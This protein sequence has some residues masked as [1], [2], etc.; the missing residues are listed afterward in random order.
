MAVDICIMI[1]DPYYF[2][3]NNKRLFDVPEC[4]FFDM[5]FS[6]HSI[7]KN[8]VPSTNIQSPSEFEA[9]ILLRVNQNRLRTLPVAKYRL[10][11][12]I[13]EQ[14]VRNRRLHYEAE[15]RFNRGVESV[16]PSEILNLKHV[17]H[18]MLNRSVRLSLK[19]HIT[20]PGIVKSA[21]KFI[22]DHM[23]T[24]IN[25]VMLNLKNIVN[26]KA[27]IEY[28]IRHDFPDIICI[29]DIKY[30]FNVIKYKTAGEILRHINE[31]FLK[32]SERVFSKVFSLAQVEYNFNIEIIDQ[33][34]IKNAINEK[35]SEGCIGCNY[36]R[37]DDICIH[38]ALMKVKDRNKILYFPYAIPTWCPNQNF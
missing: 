37:R 7:Y 18:E 9:A 4:V 13:D 31:L 21:R 36:K 8:A 10:W 29:L 34:E 22:I 20:N 17:C 38:P 5:D 35:I 32:D 12:D 23:S 19:V 26:R 28:H 11:V 2:L 3:A 6:L 1:D 33:S 30:P 16:F 24:R 25:K 27:T 14:T 15:Y